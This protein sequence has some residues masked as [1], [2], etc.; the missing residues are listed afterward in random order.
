VRLSVGICALAWVA[1]AAALPAPAISDAPTADPKTLL[2]LDR[3]TFGATAVEADRLRAMGATRWLEAQL[4]PPAQDDLPPQVQAEIA[5]LTIAQKPMPALVRDFADKS[6]AVRAITDLDL[7]VAAGK[8]YQQELNDLAKAAAARNILRDLYS[9]HQLREVM[10]WFWFNHFNVHQ[11]KGDIRAMLADYEDTLRA[12][13]LGRFR[14]L[15]EASLRHPAMLSYLDNAQNAAG[16][17]NENYAR[18]IMELHT[19]GVGSGYSQQDVEALAHILTGV[20]IDLSPQPPHLKPVLQGQ[21]ICEGLFEFNPARHDYSD[22]VF[23]GRTIKGCGFAEVEAALDLLARSPA[24]A[25]HISRE[26][27]TYFVA[28]APPTSLVDKMAKTFLHTDGNIAAVLRSMVAAPEFAASAGQKFKDPVRYVL[29][30]VRL[31]YEDRLILNTQPIQN[32]LN[33]L[34]EGLYNHETPDGYALV[35]SAWDGPGQLETRFEIARQIGSG[36][37][38]LFRPDAPGATDHPAFPQLENAFYFEGL[39]QSLRP[40]TRAVLDQAQSPQDWNILFLSSPDFM[41]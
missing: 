11:Y 8:A 13:A 7:R 17:I 23:L 5:A 39:Q 24:T 36:S 14:D 26:L 4:H 35:S 21:L 15:L 33:Q 40:A 1:G 20:G 9:P 37:A 6:K 38:G 2:L 3:L 27:A 16:H 31:A 28:D 34:A 12:H 22:K 32:W 30:A 25:R 19:M 18:E 10:T 29:S 41:R